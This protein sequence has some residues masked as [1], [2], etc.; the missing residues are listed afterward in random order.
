MRIKHI[1][2]TPQGDLT[3]LN[4]LVEGDRRLIGELVMAANED[5]DAKPHE[6]S[7]AKVKT[8]RSLDANGY[9]W[10]LIDKLAAKLRTSRTEI[11]RNV[12]REI[13]GVSTM[14]CVKAEAADALKQTWEGRGLGWQA[15]EVP[16]KLKG[17]VNLILYYGSS[18]YDTAQMAALIDRI[19]EE[20]KAQGIETMTPLEL[21]RLE[22]Y[23]V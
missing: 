8:K 16:S 6:L 10:V 18:V 7:I 20:C 11:Y 14:V 4:I 9:A 5:P 15:E 17:C 3:K 23:G 19:I 2:M 21:A 1:G 22:G 13:G 12:I